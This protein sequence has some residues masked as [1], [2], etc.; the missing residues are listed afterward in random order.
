MHSGLDRRQFLA[1]TAALPWLVGAVSLARPQPLY[2]GND[3]PILFALAEA[4]LDGLPVPEGGHAEVAAGVREAIEAA[5]P[6]L[7]TRLEQ[8]VLFLEW[9]PLIGF[10]PQRFSQMSLERRTCTLESSA[11]SMFALRRLVFRALTGL[12][13][14]VAADRPES[15]PMMGYDGPL[16]GMP[17]EAL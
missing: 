2:A 7:R 15:W 5:D 6:E 3:D 9:S 14:F 10:P 17:E 12:V 13:M 16:I 4:V 11:T 1:G 8:A